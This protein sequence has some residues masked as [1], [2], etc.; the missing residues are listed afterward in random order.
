MIDF[1][2]LNLKKSILKKRRGELMQEL[3]TLADE[4]KG[5]DLDLLVIESQGLEEDLSS[6]PGIA[7]CREAVL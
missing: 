6:P 2:D 4:I 3:A 7:F 1:E 5:I